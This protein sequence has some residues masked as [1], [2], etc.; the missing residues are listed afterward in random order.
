M[1]KALIDMPDELHKNLRRRAIDE[2]ISLKVL[3]EKALREYISHNPPNPTL[4]EQALRR[5]ETKEG[6]DQNGR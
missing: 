1:G 5:Q 6:G 2:G 3:I 4:F